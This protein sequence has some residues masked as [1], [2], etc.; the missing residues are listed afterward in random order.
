MPRND[1]STAG[2]FG[3]PELVRTSRTQGL[4]NSRLYSQPP[5]SRV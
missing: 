5:F 4:W 3:R 1:T 2:A